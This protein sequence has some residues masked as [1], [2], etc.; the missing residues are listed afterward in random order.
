MK[1]TSKKGSQKSSRKSRSRPLRK[2]RAAPKKTSGLARQN[3]ALKRE[4]AEGLEQQTATSEILHVIASSPTDV[5]PVLDAVAQRAMRLCEAYDALI[6]RVDGNIF[7]RWAHKGPITPGAL[8][9]TIN[10]GSVA[11]RA[12]LDRQVIHVEDLLSVTA[13][14]FPETEADTKHLGIRTVLVAP[15]LRESQPIGAIVI[16][17]T[18]VR[19]F[20][21]KQIALLKTFAAQ[22]VIAIENVRLFQEAQSRNRDLTESLEQQTATSEVLK[23]I[24]RSTFDL[25]PV[26][27][28]LT[29]NAV[30]L[31]GADRG[32]IYRYD[33]EYLRHALSPSDRPEV[34]EVLDR[35]PITPGRHSIGARVALERR[36]IQ[37]P[38]ILAD[39]ELT[40]GAVRI[41]SART[42]LGVPMV[43]GDDLLGVFMIRKSKVQPFTDRQIELVTTFA[44][45]AVIAI[46]NVRL[47]QELQERTSEQARSVEELKAL[48]EVGQ[49]VSSTLDLDTVLTTIIGHAVQLSGTNGGV[50]Y[51]YREATQEFVLRASHRMAKEVVEALRAVPIRLG[52][53]ATGRAAT[54]RAPVQVSD[55]RDEQ[56]LTGTRVRPTLTRLG[57][58]SLLSVPLLR[59][60]QI[61]G[62][63]T[64]WRRQAGNFEPDDVNLLQT[65]ATQS[66]LAIQNALLFREIEDKSGQLE[67]ASKH[68]SQFLANMSHELRTPMNAVLGYT[69]M[70]LTNIYGEVPEKI[71]DVL[72]RIE[73]SGRHLLDLINDVLDFSK[74]E[75]GQLILSVNTYSFKEV[76][77]NVRT[78][79][80]PLA[81]EKKL[82]LAVMLPPDLPAALGDER[83]INQ[84][85][86]N[87]VGNAIK[88]TEA[89]EVKVQ[90]TASDGALVI[91]VSDT[92]PGIPEADQQ[93]IFEEFQQTEGPGKRTKG[94]TGLGLAIAKRIVELHGGRIWVES[95]MGK[96]STFWFTLPFSRM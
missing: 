1:P 82:A 75:A 19:P 22:A 11:G 32:S 93:R 62:G 45:P 67:A 24:S 91:S 13:Q 76:I 23:V 12:I 50:I 27:E 69:R 89:G 51:E 25:Q 94:G 57:Y 56:D 54:N 66:A 10:R 40:F 96:G 8:E 41:G 78:T 18:E 87:L 34:V 65:F 80:E 43:R 86:L 20:S 88:F 37:V 61:M 73:Q 48:G 39:P 52:E 72:Q 16:R 6:H 84:V 64:V 29:E 26:L 71:Q 92:G 74:I 21:E 70:L 5:Q 79:M 35:N 33:G 31:C 95:S 59:E 17:R 83:R 28:T 90:I 49:A 85:L 81:T 42:V 60:Q 47:F 53:G 55:I 38:D 30:K 14:E 63:L 9:R 7:R 58:R 46:E 15:L 3:A 77:Q 2:R 68:K 44:D 36:A 4:V